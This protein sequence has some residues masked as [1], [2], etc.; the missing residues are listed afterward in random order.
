MA[1]PALPDIGLDFLQ[2]RCTACG[3][4]LLWKGKMKDHQPVATIEGKTAKMRRL[5]WALTHPNAPIASWVVLTTCEDERCVSPDHLVQRKRNAHHVG[6]KRPFSHRRRAAA[7][8]RARATLDL[9]AVEDIRFGGGTL[10]QAAAKHGV[11][12]AW[13]S[14]IRRCEVWKDYTSPLAALVGAA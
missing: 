9:V 14:R 7:A 10:A 6:V 11:S 3:E 2:A 4:C 5:I 12:I 13:A 1:R 8:Q